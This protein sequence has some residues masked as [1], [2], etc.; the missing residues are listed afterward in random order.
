MAATDDDRVAITGVGMVA[1]L[2]H[3]AVT[4]CAAARAGLSRAAEL[5]VLNFAAD[6]R[7]GNEPVVGHT[8][9]RLAE[10]FVG[11]GK[12]TLLAETALRDA[13]NRAGLRPE[14]SGETG[15]FVN[16]SDQYFERAASEGGAESGGDGSPPQDDAAL[17]VS[18]AEQVALVQR[19]AARNGWSEAYGGATH[20]GHAGFASALRDALH[21]IE[22]GVLD[23]ALV[24]GVDACVD[25]RALVAAEAC[26]VLKTAANP[27]GF[28]P[29][30]AAA[31]VVL[32][33]VRTARSRGAVADV[34]VE[35]PALEREAYHRLAGE[36]PIGRALAR[37]AAAAL[38]ASG[39]R[40]EAFVVADLNGDPFRAQEWGYALVRL[41]ERW[42]LGD[43]PLWLPALAFGEVGAATGTVA[44]CVAVRALQRGYAPA[45]RALI[46]L[47]GDDER[48]A[49]F[50][51]TASH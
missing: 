35:P 6:E 1:A 10:G 36:P 39:G 20:G 25:P 15:L 43:R 33:R 22:T 23:R 21:A 17:E 14:A 38:G 11:I 16:F 40:A 44:L 51:V 48:R 47:A 50:C 28:M 4:N 8:V 34:L 37:A 41:A 13:V 2:G 12:L 3:D 19:L 32:E 7:W 24:G 27:V 42:R 45:G 5:D 18:R 49:A 9:A 26:G 30:E 46:V 31:F 29:G